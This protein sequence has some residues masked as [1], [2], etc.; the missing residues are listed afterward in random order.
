VEYP[1]L[2]R[3]LS[4]SRT[5]LDTKMSKF[6]SMRRLGWCAMRT[7]GLILVRAQMSLR[8]MDSVAARVALHRSVR[9]RG[10]KLSR[11]RADPKS[12]WWCMSFSSWSVRCFLA[13][14]SISIRPSSRCGP[15]LPFIVPKGRAWVIFVVKR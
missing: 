14:G 13:Y 4:M 2:A 9:S 1:Y 8:P 7:Q 15:C 6:V 5:T 3:Q 10:Y 12:L 11:E